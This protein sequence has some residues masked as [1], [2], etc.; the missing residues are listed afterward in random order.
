[1]AKRNPTES[2]FLVPGYGGLEVYLTEFSDDHNAITEEVTVLNSSFQQ[3]AYVGVQS[4]EISMAGFYDDDTASAVKATGGLTGALT[5][6]LANAQVMAWGVE[7][8]ATGQRFMGWSGAM[9]T[10]FEITPSRDALTK[11]KANIKNSG[12]IEEGKIIRPLSAATATGFGAGNAAAASGGQ[13]INFGASNVS[14]AAA[15]LI[16]THVEA[17]A[18][19]ISVEIMHSA[20]NLTFSSYGGFNNVSASALNSSYGQR[21]NS[22]APIQQYVTE[23]HRD[24]GGSSFT[25]GIF[26][27]GLA[28]H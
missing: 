7:G 10:K 23:R 28:P 20:D 16:F 25:S 4:G 3:H 22:T 6:G 26:F 19:G 11:M 24:A 12:K 18:S 14:G 2:W 21:I 15:Y 1:M 13:A 9:V 5:S 17:A 8:T 27:V